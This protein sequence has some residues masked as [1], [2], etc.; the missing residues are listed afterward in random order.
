MTETLN[1]MLGG[2]NSKYLMFRRVPTDTNLLVY[3]IFFYSIPNNNTDL[4]AFVNKQFAPSYK[5][6]VTSA[7][8]LKA[9]LREQTPDKRACSI[10]VWIPEADATRF[11]SK[12]LFL[13]KYK[14]A[15]AMWHATSTTLCT[16]CW[17]YGHPRVVLHTEL[18]KG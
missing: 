4:S 15:K 8:F 2:E 7:K 6:D 12:F 5:V 13:G 1:D 17:K 16:K 3:G 14:E 10:I 9:E 18:L 11:E